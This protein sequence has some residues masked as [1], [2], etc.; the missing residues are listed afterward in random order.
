MENKRKKEIKRDR[1]KEVKAPKLF[2]LKCSVCS[3]KVGE[4]ELPYYMQ[5]VELKDIKR[6]DLGLGEIRCNDHTMT[7]DERVKSGRT[8]EDIE[9][10][11]ERIRIV[12]E[13]ENKDKQPK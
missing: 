1:T 9:A 12:R 10:E 3:T 13:Q 5:G 7:L 11:E 2:T 6:K 8:K 4:I